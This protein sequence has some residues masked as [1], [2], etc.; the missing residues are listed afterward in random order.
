MLAG[1]TVLILK[2]S[3]AP[4]P[5][6]E[7]LRHQL[8]RRED[9]MFF[10]SETNAFTGVMIDRYDNGALRSRTTL[11][12]GLA[13]GLSEGWYTNGVLQVSEHFTNGVSHG[14]RVKYYPTG[15]RLSETPVVAGKVD[16]LYRRW[17]PEGGLADEIPMRDDQPDGES[18]SF[19]PDGSPKAR[20][21]VRNGKVIEQSFFPGNDAATNSLSQTR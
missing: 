14:L 18:R 10:G 20:A 4:L 11:R 21:L 3:P 5:E 16:G 19:H 2:H 6:R 1:A 13:H 17:H 12:A 9:R 7:A 8:S 15:R